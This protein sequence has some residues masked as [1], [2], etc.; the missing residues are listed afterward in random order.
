M[1][2]KKRNTTKIPKSKAKTAYGVLSDVAT[3]ALKEPMRIAMATWRQQGDPGETIPSDSIF[4]LRTVTLPKCGTVGCIGGWTETIV[5]VRRGR[6][7]SAMAILG[8]DS[9][10]QNELFYPKALT[11][12][13]V[14]QTQEHA[15]AVVTHI[16][17]F[18]KKYK[19]QLLAKAVRS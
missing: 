18:Q 6:Y 13:P 9:A 14:Q 2:S 7:H 8:L 4:A 3:L 10:Q 19:A 17:K 5:P 16:R 1:N 12:A 11:D 15:L